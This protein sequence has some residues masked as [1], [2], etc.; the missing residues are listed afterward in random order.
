MNS[1]MLMTMASALSDPTR[2]LLLYLLGRGPQT[3]GQLV[4]PLR[5]SVAP[6]VSR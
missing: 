1:T 4:A 5:V 6:P 2:L 3:V